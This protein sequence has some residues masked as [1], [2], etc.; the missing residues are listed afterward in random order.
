MAMA[1][2]SSASAPRS[3]F[4]LRRRPGFLAVVILLFLSL[5]GMDDAHKTI[6]YTDQ[7]DQIKLFKVTTR[8][9]LSSSIWKNP[10]LPKHTQPL[11]ETVFRRKRKEDRTQELLQVDR[12]AEL[13]MRNVAT[14][15]SRN[16]SNKVRA[17][18]NI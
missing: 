1:I 2:S 15:R 18:Y 4:P 12:E 14:N 7:D 6:A 11:A 9:F 16:F 10:L 8:E 3:M 5:Q 13:H 17:S